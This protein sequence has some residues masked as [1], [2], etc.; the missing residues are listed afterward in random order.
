MSFINT[1]MINMN[2]RFKNANEAYEFL[3][4]Q[5]IQYGED[6]DNTKAN[7]ANGV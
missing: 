7:S 4:D 5:T 2:T 3:L 6:F 1:I